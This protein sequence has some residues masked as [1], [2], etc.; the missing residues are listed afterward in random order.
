MARLYDD[1]SSEFLRRTSVAITDY[2][3]TAS[4]QFQVDTLPTVAGDEMTL[5][6]MSSAGFNTNFWNMRL[7]DVADTLQFRVADGSGGNTANGEAIT[8][9]TWHHGCCRGISTTDRDVILDGDITNRGTNTATRSYGSGHN[10]TTI[11]SIDIAS[12]QNFMSGL[13]GEVAIW[14]IA[15]SDNEVIALSR[16]VNASSIRPGNLVHYNPIWGLES[17]EPDYSG[18]SNNMTVTGTVKG[19]HAPVTLFT[20]KWAATIPL[21]EVAAV[22]GFVHS[23][24]I[25]IG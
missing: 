1:A 18:N 11:G 23:Q 20:P 22:A 21:I 13:I 12:N 15:L 10:R 4:C 24:A 25:I 19:N 3:F 9:D 5:I 16:G 7:D 2:P 17:P 6:A 8:V 14:N